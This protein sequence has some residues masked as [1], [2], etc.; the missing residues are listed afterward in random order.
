MLDD[1]DTQDGLARLQRAASLAHEGGDLHAVFAAKLPILGILSDRSGPAAGSSILAEV[2]QI[3]TKLGDPEIT[4]R[5]RLFVAQT[6]A[7]RGLLDNAKR[8][9]L[10]ARRILRVSPN[11]YLDAFTG[12]LDLAIAV[13]RSEFDAARE[14]GFRA[15][16]SAKQS[17]VA[18]IQRAV[19]GNLGNLFY[20]LGDFDRATAYFEQALA[21]PPT[22]AVNIASILDSLAK[23]HLIKNRPG[24]CQAELDKIESSMHA[25]QDRFSYEHRYAALTR[26]RPQPARIGELRRA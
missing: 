9:T 15:V 1:G 18:K 23:I 8:H 26:R 4:A 16:E 2:R 24:E 19:L 11:S 14:C 25:E 17:G 5:L 22:N 20:E 6:E 7:K 10:V 12:N 13:L 3:A 21:A